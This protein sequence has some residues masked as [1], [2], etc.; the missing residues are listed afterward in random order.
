MLRL[1]DLRAPSKVV[2]LSKCLGNGKP[3]NRIV[4]VDSCRH[5]LFTSGTRLSRKHIRTLGV[6]ESHCEFTKT[7]VLK[8]AAD[9]P[10]IGP[11]GLV[12][13]LHESPVIVVGKTVVNSILNVGRGW[14][15]FVP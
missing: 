8:P 6:D 2:Y 7:L 12:K 11:F 13:H 4:A 3:R 10:S 1:L 5:E 14:F 9:R 15:I